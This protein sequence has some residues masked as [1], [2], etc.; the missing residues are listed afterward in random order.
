MQALLL[1]LLLHLLLLLLPLLPLLPMLLS[2][3]HKAQPAH[4]GY[5]LQ[6]KAKSEVRRMCK[7]FQIKIE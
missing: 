7:D 4:E 3:W 5:E 6:V 2:C 1:S